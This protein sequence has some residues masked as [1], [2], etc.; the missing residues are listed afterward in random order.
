M[1]DIKVLK[2]AVA[3]YM[4]SPAGTELHWDDLTGQRQRYFIG[5][6]KSILHALEYDGFE[7]V[8]NTIS[9]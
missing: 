8:A 3:I 7:L 5:R 2:L 9:E 6:A 4:A 1:Q